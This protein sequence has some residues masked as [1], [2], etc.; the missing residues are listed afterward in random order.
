MRRFTVYAGDVFM[1]ELGAQFDEKSSSS[2]V[3]LRNIA[4]QT[5]QSGSGDG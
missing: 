3:S 1:T 5:E 4:P 2:V